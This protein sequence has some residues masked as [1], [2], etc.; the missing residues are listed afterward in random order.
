VRTDAALDIA[1]LLG[2]DLPVTVGQLIIAGLI[3]AVVGSSERGFLLAAA[4]IRRI[5]RRLMPEP[6]WDITQAVATLGPWPVRRAPLWC[7]HVGRRG[8]PA[9][10]GPIAV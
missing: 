5:L 6:A 2:T 1:H 3:V 7:R 10:P 4:V 8:P 9:I